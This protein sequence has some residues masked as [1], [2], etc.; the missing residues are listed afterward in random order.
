[1]PMKLSSLEENQ[2]RVLNAIDCQMLEPDGEF[3]FAQTASR[4]KLAPDGFVKT[5]ELGIWGLRF[6]SV[7]SKV[8]LRPI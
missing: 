5:A 2:A 1:M 6:C 7:V 8:T 3:L 4:L